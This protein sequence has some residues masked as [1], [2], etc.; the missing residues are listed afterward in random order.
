MKQAIAQCV[1]GVGGIPSHSP[2]GLGAF[3]RVQSSGSWERAVLHNS[4]LPPLQ[5]PP[6][7]SGGGGGDG[8]QGEIARA[9]QGKLWYPPLQ[10]NRTQVKRLLN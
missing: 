8:R 3:E 5:C 9:F 7:A 10:A 2:W 1:W 4:T 6:V